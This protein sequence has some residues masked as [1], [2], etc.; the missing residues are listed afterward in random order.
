M[1][2]AL[3]VLACICCVET[4]EPYEMQAK[5]VQ[6]MRRVPP[7]GAVGAAIALVLYLL[8]SSSRQAG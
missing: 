3:L 5:H 8:F 4:D 2:L 6:R 1:T 7:P